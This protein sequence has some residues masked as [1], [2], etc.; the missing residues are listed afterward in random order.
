MTARIMIA[1][2]GSNSGK[3]SFTVGIL[4][5]LR[6]RGLRV[7]A[8]KVG[9]DFIDPSHH[10]AASGRP[11]VNLDA[12]FHGR[13][14]VLQLLQD[15][16]ADAD[17][18]IVEGV[19]GLFDG[20][21]SGRSLASSSA[22]MARWTR[23]PV[24]LV[25][26]ASGMAGSAAAV[27]KGYAGFSRGVHIAGVLV[28]RVGSERHYRLI[29]DALAAHG[30][31]PAVGYLS[32]E[33]AWQRPSRHL[34]LVPSLELDDMPGYLDR[35]GRAVEETVDLDC[36]LH[37]AQTADP[38]PEPPLPRPATPLP[39]VTVAYAYDA[40]FHFY[41]TAGLK[42]LQ[43]LGAHLVPFSP[44]AGED[45]PSGTQA[46][47]L[48]GGFPEL[49]AEELASRTTPIAA[50]RAFDGPIYAECGGMMYLARS[51][52]LADGRKIPMLG[53][54]PADVAMQERLQALGYGEAQML[55]A[56]ILGPAGT[57]LRGHEF[58]WSSLSAGSPFAM[59]VHRSGRAPLVDGFAGRRL[60]ASYFHI[61]FA[62][63]RRAARSFLEAAGR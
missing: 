17:V 25:V 3:T 26:D 52:T 63:N 51:L 57:A 10:L 2:T 41:Y 16:M 5:A 54:V 15:Y 11:S 28:N 43:E 34:G 27:V 61:D 39:R 49:Y 19:M 47:L 33:K 38:L 18:G 1:G 23:T 40:A 29:A 7:Q 12:F 22:E 6:R 32:Q 14:L 13:R 44:L 21:G 62:A 60:L 55:V 31:P 58:H 53:R 46:L 30:L 24:L 36:I 37:L 48:G 35:L 42:A 56:S 4:A 8:F 50:I 20:R 59:E 45:L 9:P